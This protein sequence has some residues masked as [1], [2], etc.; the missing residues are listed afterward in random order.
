M[1][2]LNSKAGRGTGVFCGSVVSG[3]G[4]WVTRSG[5]EGAGVDSAWE[6][7]VFSGSGDETVSCKK[8]KAVK[9][10][11][12]RVD[13]FLRRGMGELPEAPWR[14]GV[15]WRSR[16]VFRRVSGGDRRCEGS[17]PCNPSVSQSVS[18]GSSHVPFPSSFSLSL[19]I[20]V[21][22]E[23]SS[24]F[25]SLKT[26]RGFSSRAP[27]FLRFKHQGKTGPAQ[28][29]KMIL[30]PFT[31][32]LNAKRIMPTSK[33]YKNQIKYIYADWNKDLVHV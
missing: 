1:P 31:S 20:T 32:L 4:G 22:C 13:R 27:A 33:Y 2:S 29:G 10:R 14:E 28:L 26:G 15:F 19:A 30:L 24:S 16:C 23:A 9:G 25:H 18:L 21:K 6:I 7:P 3:V 12:I 11:S 17:P 8:A 5:E